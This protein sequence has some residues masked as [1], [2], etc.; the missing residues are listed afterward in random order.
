M[1]EQ[2]TQIARQGGPR[3]W[4]SEDKVGGVCLEIESGPGWPEQS[5][6]V[7]ASRRRRAEP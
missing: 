1:R 4:G 2:A 5:E 3:E 6:R 7:S